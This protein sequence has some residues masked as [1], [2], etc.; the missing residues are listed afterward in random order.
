MEVDNKT[1]SG[2]GFAWLTVPVLVMILANLAPV[3]GVLYLGWTVFPVILFF[4]YY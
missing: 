2:A 1:K 3:Y 4:W